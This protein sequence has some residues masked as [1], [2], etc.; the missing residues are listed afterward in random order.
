[1]LFPL[2]FLELKRNKDEYLSLWS[3]Q[4]WLRIQAT[5]NT[6]WIRWESA[7]VGG[8]DCLT[9][10]R[11][12]LGN[13]A[14]L[15]WITPFSPFGTQPHLHERVH[16]SISGLE[17]QQLTPS[18]GILVGGEEGGRAKQRGGCIVSLAIDLPYLIAVAPKSVILKESPKAGSIRPSVSDTLG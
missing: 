7:G 4:V 6:G 2:L 10:L 14:I 1:M 16:D 12:A 3:T 13:E 5:P 15:A 17:S 8:T 18:K 11:S 9:D